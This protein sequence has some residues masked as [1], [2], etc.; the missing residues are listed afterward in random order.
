MK[1]L[2]EDPKAPPPK[3]RLFRRIRRWVLV[4][5]LAVVT[6]TWFVQHHVVSSAA[7]F[8]FTAGGVPKAECILVPGAA[9][10]QDGTPYPMLV[11]RLAIAKELY[12][13]GK[14]PL[15]VVSG[16]GGGG[17]AVDEVAAMRH[18]LERK[19]V[20]AEAIED[21]P[22]GLR[23][24]DSL[25][26]CRS[27]Y[28]H[29]SVISV[30]NRFHVPRMIFLGKHCGLKSFGVVA[31]PLY[32][33]SVGTLWRNRGREILARVRAWLDVYVLGID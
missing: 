6:T 7:P 9:I 14:A 27:V 33:Y 13:L 26:R 10:Y 24:V 30:S 32:R 25:R 19:G 21:D 18:W 29:R 3:R 12:G 5:T 15:I 20:P 8:L 4:V 17:V 31:P 11:D 1:E 16:R 28:G 22:L 2:E 23:T